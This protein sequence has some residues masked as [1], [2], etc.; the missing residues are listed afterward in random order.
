MSI[1]SM[2]LELWQFSFIKDRPEIRKSEIFSSE[3]CPIYQDWNKSKIPNL[4]RMF[5]IKYYRIQQ[6]SRVTALTVSVLLR[7]NQQGVQILTPPPPP[8][9]SHTHTHTYTHIH[10]YIRVNKDFHLY[11]YR[12]WLTAHSRTRNFQVV[13]NRKTHQSARL[14]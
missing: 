8:P 12:F 5:L 13:K 4:V 11:K 3:F 10:T 9:P 1:S 6:N 7:E 14:C 2:V